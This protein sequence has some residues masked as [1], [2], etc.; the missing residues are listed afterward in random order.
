MLISFLPCF[1]SA[2]DR[3]TAVV[4]GAY[5]TSFYPGGQEKG[6]SWS[7]YDFEATLSGCSWT[8][9]CDGPTSSTRAGEPRLK[10]VQSCDGTNIYLVELQDKEMDR[11]AWGDRYASVKSQLPVAL[12]E[13]FPGTFPPQGRPIRDIWFALASSCL[14]S[15]LSGTI[16]SLGSQDLAV[17]YRTNFYENYFWRD[18]PD[19]PG[20]REIVLTNDGHY[21]A[22]DAASR[23]MLNARYAAPY[24]KGWTVGVGVYHRWTNVAGIFVPLDFEYTGYSPSLSGKVASDL[25][26]VKVWKCTVTRFR[27]GVAEQIPP[28]LP[29]G[30]VHVKDR[31]F[32]QAGYASVGYAVTNGHWLAEN[33]PHLLNLVAHA[34]RMSL[35]VEQ[36]HTLPSDP[37]LRKYLIWCL[38]ILPLSAV[39]LKGLFDKLILVRVQAETNNPG[40]CTD[41]PHPVLV[42]SQ[43]WQARL[44]GLH[45]P[46]HV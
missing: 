28:A 17:F 4:S 32:I 30:N 29:K 18:R 12:A 27:V 46:G 25:L 8:I 11:K 19:E 14:T 10:Y 31:R 35:D 38:L 20:A 2:E 26:R 7:K 21:F 22:W 9:A 36:G 33:D 43:P 40:P 3:G 5:E 39:A 37:R 15:N 34:R 41:A 42:R 13:T 1:A 23:K 6:A 45:H 24:D 16:K 44:Q